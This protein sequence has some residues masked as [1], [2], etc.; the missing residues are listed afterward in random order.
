MTG[1]TFSKCQ[2]IAIWLWYDMVRHGLKRWAW[3]AYS[4][5]HD[6]KQKKEKLKHTNISRL[7]PVSQCVRWSWASA[8]IW[9]WV[10]YEKI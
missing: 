8:E 4:S 1:Q 7:Y 5:T 6:Q 3:S 9:G 2:R 10:W